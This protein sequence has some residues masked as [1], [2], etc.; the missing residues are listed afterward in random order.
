MAPRS[1]N[2]GPP[3]WNDP[4]VVR[5]FASRDADHRLLALLP[6]YAEPGTTR[7][8]DLGCAGGRNA[9]LLAESGFDLWAVDV[10]E[11]MV[12]HTRERVARSR[13]V[14]EA[15]RRV[16]TG[17]MT[18]LSEVAGRPFDLVV[19]LGIYHQA[20]T[21][22]EYF[23]ALDETERVLAPAGR[24][25]VSS[26][27]PGTGLFDAPAPRVAG[28]R[29]VYGGLSGRTLCLRDRDGLDADFAARGLVP[30]VPSEVVTR[31]LEDRRRVTVN[32]LYRRSP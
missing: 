22:D 18:D 24:V 13:G 3:D 19:A 20:Q 9:E 2:D 29:F 6:T 8:L 23:A 14:E 5:R 28:T 7:V 26:F 11:A 32:A 17:R 16:R 27:A 21:E 25:L 31:E 10:A 15:V 4:E 30:E 1:P 12:R